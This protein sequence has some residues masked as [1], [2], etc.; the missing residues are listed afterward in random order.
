[1]ADTFHI[2]TNNDVLVW[3]RESIVLSRNKAAERIKI[4]V[5]CLEQLENGTKFPSM[6]ELK[7]M[8]KIYKRSI[9]TLLLKKPPQE[10]ALPKDRRTVNSEEIGN[11]SEKTILAVR[12]ARAFVN[13]LAELKKEFNIPL[14]SFDYTAK[15][16]DDPKVIAQKLRNELKLSE[17]KEIESAADALDIYIRQLES[18]GIAVFQISLTQDNLRGFS[19]VDEQM[20]VIVLKRGGE[21]S[22][23]KNFTLFHELGHILLNE[24]GLCDITFTPNSQEIEKWCNAFAAEILVPSHE[25]LKLENVVKHRINNVFVWQNK[26]LV[27]IGNSFHVGPLVILRRLLENKLTTNDFYEKKHLSWNKP[28]F[29]RSKTPEGRNIPKETIKEK[30]FNYLSLAF[31]AYDKNKIDL[32]DLSDFIGVKL[33][34]IPK[35]RQLLNI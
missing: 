33:S 21:T 24:G 12:K 30:G 13:S 34:Y 11:F 28:S 14:T 6:L 19:L 15:I 1:M 9:A 23:A 4:S 2:R 22:T 25:L 7:A 35:T 17:V 3:A 5:K 18:F 32:K 26:E 29:G 27:E 8:S 16:W 20:P 31:N 10:K